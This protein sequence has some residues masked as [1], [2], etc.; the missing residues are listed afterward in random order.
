MKKIVYLLCISAPM[1]FFTSCFEKIDNWYTETSGL[2][3]RYVVAT[4]CEEYSDDDTSIEDGNEVMIYNTAANVNDEIWIDTYVAGDSI[5]GK[6]KITG[7]ASGFKGAA[8]DA[9]NVRVTTLLIDTDYGLAP[10]T[11]AYAGYF[12]VPTAA[13]QLNDGLQL[14]TRITLVEGKIIPKGA[15]TIGGNVSDS[16]YLKTIMHHD[17]VQFISYQLPEEEWE[18]EGVPEFGWQLKPGSNS[19]AD[20]DGY[21]E[22]WTLAGYRYTGFQEDF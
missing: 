22:T 5:K 4:T 20:A 18:E 14:Y 3:G 6:F 9:Q 21:D 16:V 11:D 7:D 15:T 12:R 10:F 2:D 17:Y 1:M 19:P 13:G 8:G